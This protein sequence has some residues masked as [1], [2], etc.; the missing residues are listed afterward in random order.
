M[1][2]RSN[3]ESNNCN[4]CNLKHTRNSKQL[5]PWVLEVSLEAQ[6]ALDSVEV[7]QWAC[8][9]HR[10]AL[11]SKDFRT[12]QIKLEMPQIELLAVL[13][14]GIRVRPWINCTTK[15][16]K[17]MNK[18]S[19][20]LMVNRPTEI[21]K[22]QIKTWLRS[23]RGRMLESKAVYHGVLAFLRQRRLQTL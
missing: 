8:S 3:R 7:N 18:F 2:D 19:Q 23:R 9:K 1:I 5:L 15:E 17:T 16:T 6:R 20:Q 10:I 13:P 11:S 21:G 12:K 22:L 4:K 14:T